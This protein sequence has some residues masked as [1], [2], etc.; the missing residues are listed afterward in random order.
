MKNIKEPLGTIK[1]AKEPQ[2]IPRNP[3]LVKQDG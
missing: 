3:Y 2:G 1:N